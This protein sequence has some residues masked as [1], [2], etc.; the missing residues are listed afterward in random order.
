LKTVLKAVLAAVDFQN[1]LGP[2]TDEVRY[3]WADWGLL[4]EMSIGKR[5]TLQ[6]PPEALLGIC[7]PPA[8]SSGA[9]CS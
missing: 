4:A 9:K 8:E 1:Q 3:I 2:M 5:N 6:M 7:H